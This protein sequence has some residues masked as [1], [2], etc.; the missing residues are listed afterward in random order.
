MKICMKLAIIGR[1][2]ALRK[3][4]KHVSKKGKISRRVL[5]EK[6]L[7][8]NLDAR[9][10]YHVRLAKEGVYELFKIHVLVASVWLNYDRHQYDRK[11]IDSFVVNHINEIKTDNRLENLEIITQA[12][13][14]QKYWEN[15]RKRNESKIGI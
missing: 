4:S 5:K 8:P 1:V 12:E 3:T 6:M 11:D 2:K 9:G 7:K 15:K 13:N 14:I 10:Y